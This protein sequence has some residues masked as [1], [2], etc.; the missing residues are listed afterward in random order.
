[1]NGDTHLHPT[2]RFQINTNTG[3]SV[4]IVV[5]GFAGFFTIMNVLNAMKAEIVLARTETASLKME[6]NAKIDKTDGK[7]SEIEGNKSAVTTTEFFRW[8]VHLQQSNP[9]IKV[10][11]PEV[12]K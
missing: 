1:M 2:G 4:G 6:L 5:L 10:P 12:A 9:T 8:A 11:E 7:V 3:I